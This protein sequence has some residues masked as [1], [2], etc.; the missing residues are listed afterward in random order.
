MRVLPLA[1]CALLFAAPLRAEE[2][3]QAAADRLGYA[4]EHPRILAQQRL[5]GIAHGVSL[6][7][8]AC[9]DLPDAS[10]AAQDAYAPWRAKQEAAVDAAIAELGAYYFG[11]DTPMPDWQ[12]LAQAMHLPDAL[13]YAPDS[14]DLKAACATLP[15][16]LAQPRYDLAERYR[17]EELMARTVAAFEVESRNTYCHKLLPEP[18]REIHEA[19]YAVWREI[20]EPLRQ[21]AAAELESAWP[22]DAPD[23]SFADWLA[24][25]RRDTRVRGSLTDCIAFSESLRRPEAALRNTFRLPPAAGAGTQK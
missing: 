17:L 11:D 4:F 13:P 15:Q 5:F 12:A 25:V 3:Q 18:L 20:N 16:A 7:A 14:E 19:R 8:A 24:G 23:A 1:L 22:D 6:L 21:Q 2:A 9:L 10:Q